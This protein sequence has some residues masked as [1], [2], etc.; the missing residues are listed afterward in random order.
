MSLDIASFLSGVIGK[1]V[2]I[3]KT[4]NAGEGT[5]TLPDKPDEFSLGHVEF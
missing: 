5:A 1:E 2:L 3:S 4:D